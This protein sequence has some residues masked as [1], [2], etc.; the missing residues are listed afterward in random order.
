M[1]AIW[2]EKRLY[3]DWISFFVYFR[4]NSPTCCEVFKTYLEPLVKDYEPNDDDVPLVTDISSST[5]WFFL[6]DE[7]IK[8]KKL[9]HSDAASWQSSDL[10]HE[11]TQWWWTNE[12]ECNHIILFD[13]HKVE[14]KNN[15]LSDTRSLVVVWIKLYNLWNLFIMGDDISDLT[16]ML[17]REIDTV[18]C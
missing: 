14:W 10:S 17:D 16:P 8:L 5:S 2:V 9:F 6:F 18:V 15:V 4:L 11:N 13:T 12:K 3:F 1:D 7:K